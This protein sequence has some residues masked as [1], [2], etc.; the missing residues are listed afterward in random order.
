MRTTEEH[1]IT[2]ELDG[3]NYS[4]MIESVLFEGR[5]YSSRRELM[6]ARAK[7]QTKGI[8]KI[9]AALIPFIVALNS[10]RS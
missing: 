1:Y 3:G 9:L 2:W 8:A 4:K 7:S 5:L 10:N 6:I